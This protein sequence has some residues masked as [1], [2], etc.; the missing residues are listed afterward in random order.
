MDTEEG[1]TSNHRTS[2]FRILKVQEIVYRSLGACEVA[3][4]KDRPGDAEGEDGGAGVAGDEGVFVAEPEVEGEIGIW[5]DIADAE[6]CGGAGELLID[7]GTVGAIDRLTRGVEFG[8]IGAADAIAGEGLEVPAGAAVVEGMAIAE[9]EG[10]EDQVGLVGSE[11]VDA[12]LAADLIAFCNGEADMK[13]GAD[14]GSGVSFCDQLG[15]F[16]LGVEGCARGEANSNK[17]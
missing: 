9:E 8:D 4:G 17:E 2:F 15:E 13:I 3:G 6:P 1:E 14:T 11:I 12:D 16:E 10:N 7:F 5:E